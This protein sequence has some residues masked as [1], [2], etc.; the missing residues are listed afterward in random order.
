[1]TDLARF[2]EAQ[3]GV[4]ETAL[5][6]LRAGR[7]GSHWMWFI[8]PQLAALGRS[9][10]AKAYGIADLAEARDYM[11]DPLLGPRYRACARAVTAHAGRTAESILGPVDA[12]KLH[13]SATLMAAAGGGPEVRRILAVFYDGRP[14]ERTEALIGA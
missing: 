6:E 8:F 12:L 7:K 2:R 3:A 4:Y 14:C 5:A 10:T 9:P 13:S 1:M 11:A